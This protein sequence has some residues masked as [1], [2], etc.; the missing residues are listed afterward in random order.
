MS[1]DVA[2]ELDCVYKNRHVNYVDVNTIFTV[3]DTN[4]KKYVQIYDTNITKL[5]LESKK[6]VAFNYYHAGMIRLKKAGK[7]NTSVLENFWQESLLFIN[8]KSHKQLKVAIQQEVILLETYFQDHQLKVAELLATHATA[9]CPLELSIDIVNVIIADLISHIS[10]VSFPICLEF[11]EKREP[12]FFSYFHTLKQSA[13]AKNLDDFF[14]QNNLSDISKNKKLLICSL[15]L[16]GVDPIVSM[17]S[18]YQLEKRSRNDCLNIPSVSY[19]TRVSIDEII[20]FDQSFPQGTIFNLSLT[21]NKDQYE[22]Q[23]LTPINFGFGA[24]KCLGANLSRLI[25]DSAIRFLNG[26][27]KKESLPNFTIATEGTFLKF[28]KY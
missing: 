13:M 16:M 26:S 1:L 9:S 18:S 12:V 14:D 8:D 7:V 10:S 2:K 15:V 23:N 25:I 21:P 11:I 3:I 4:Q 19:I 6:L 22:S 28:K 17:V 24:H 5:L 20:V 27:I